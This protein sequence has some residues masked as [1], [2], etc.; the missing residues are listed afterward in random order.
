MYYHTHE[1]RTPRSSNHFTHSSRHNTPDIHASGIYLHM[2]ACPLRVGLAPRTFAERVLCLVLY[3]G[4]RGWAAGCEVSVG[5]GRD[6]PDGCVCA[7]PSAGCREGTMRKPGG[8]SCRISSINGPISRDC[9][10][11]IGED[12][13]RPTGDAITERKTPHQEFLSTCG[14]GGVFH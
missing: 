4:A 11:N 5:C 1:E 3:V 7:D 8:Q 6:K 9:G 14:F 2:A 10:T 12:R 13:Y